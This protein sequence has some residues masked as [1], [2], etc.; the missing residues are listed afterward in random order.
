MIGKLERGWNQVMK[1]EGIVLKTRDVYG[2]MKEKMDTFIHKVLLNPTMIMI[3]FAFLLGRAVMLDEMTPFGLPFFATIYMLKRKKSIL[4]ILA[5]LVGSV[6]NIP[7][8]SVYLLV[9]V[10]FFFLFEKIYGVTSETWTKRLPIAVLSA[11]VASRFAL[12]IGMDKGIAWLDVALVTVEGL[13]VGLL[14]L[15]F[16]HS[17]PQLY[18]Q[19]RKQ[20]LRTEEVISFLILLASIMTGTIGW[21]VFDLSVENI[22]ARYIVLLFAFVSG[23]AMGSTV[24]VVIGLILGFSNINNLYQLSL[25]AF[26]GLLGGL[27]REGKK[28]GVTFGLF[29]GTLLIGLYSAPFEQVNQ[30]VS[31]TLVSIALFLL[32]PRQVTNKLASYIPGT[33][34][35]ASEEQQYLRK[36]RDVTAHRI[37]QFSTLFRTLSNSFK[38]PVLFQDESKQTREVDLFLSNITEKTC[39]TC[40]RKKYCW[41]THFNTTYDFM[42]DIMMECEKSQSKSLPLALSREWEK[43][44]VKPAKVIQMVEDEIS[45]YRMNQDL[46]KQV[47]ESRKLVSDQL[48]GISQVMENF[49]EEIKRERANLYEQ[50]EEIIEMF[51]HHGID[52]EHLEIYCA[53]KG[54]IDIEITMY[55]DGL[56]IAEK[57]IAPML[58]DLFDETIEIKREERKNESDLYT[59]S[60][61]STQA[62]VLETGI[63]SAAKGGGFIS[64]DSH[65]TIEI[66]TGKIALAISD[67]MGNGERAHA[68]SHETIQLLQ[69]I[70]QSG[71]DEQIAIQSVNS[72]LSLRTTDEIFSTLDLVMVDLQKATAKFLKV[73]SSPSFIKRGQTVH[74]VTSTNLP[75]GIFNEVDVDVETE[76][77]KAGDLLVMMSDGVYDAPKFAANKDIW[78]KRKIREMQTN[79]PQEVADLI[80]EEVIRSQSGQIADDMTIVVAKIKR[81]IPKWAAIPAY[82]APT[83]RKKRVSSL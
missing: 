61:G 35:Y 62:F 18:I 25:L 10:F 55:E 1:A 70:L 33:Q 26:S 47:L 81:N 59:F 45:Y 74:M 24:G 4:V 57:I 15:I 50:E 42:K 65:S 63:A 39:Q 43:H 71:I 79:D 58:S 83:Y 72:I 78:L 73:G 16:I 7:F 3:A 32:T 56:G 36:L 37:E 51:E 40:F 49:A 28:I 53:Q 46:K 14:T 31:E 38:D 48:K 80:M 11:S 41:S 21:F 6:S 75:I 9:G 68:E 27:L 60:L 52:I 22:L 19:K 12:L 44:C 66:G 54:N 30:M 69:K 23:A 82:Q 5:M 2:S 17:L 34:E 8:H 76:Q 13:L 77:L 20:P 64:G 67:G 29:I